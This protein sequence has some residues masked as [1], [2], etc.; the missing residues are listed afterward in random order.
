VADTGRR[1][2]DE[3]VKFV[4]EGK[5]IMGICNGFQLLVKTGL[6]PA[7]GD[8]HTENSRQPDGKTWAGS[9]AAGSI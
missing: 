3:L 7:L 8:R 1:F 6:L 4:D 9:R 5:V 2:L